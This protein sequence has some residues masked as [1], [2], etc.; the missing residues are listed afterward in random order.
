MATGLSLVPILT[1]KKQP[2]PAPTSVVSTHDKEQLFSFC[3]QEEPYVMNIGTETA[4]TGNDQFEGFCVDLLAE[5][6]EKVNFQYEIRLVPDAKY[7][8][9]DEND[10]WNGMVKQLIDGVSIQ[11][12]FKRTIFLSASK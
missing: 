7:G 6:A 1:S 11:L 8:A 9:P 2:I 12:L 4:L 5:I 3:H 10:Q